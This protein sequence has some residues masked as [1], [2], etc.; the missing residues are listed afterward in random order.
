MKN[1]ELN[2]NISM[3]ELPLAALHKVADT[4]AHNMS[5]LLVT[6]SAAPLVGKRRMSSI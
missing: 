6:P 2:A 4:H 1:T 3:D 5:V